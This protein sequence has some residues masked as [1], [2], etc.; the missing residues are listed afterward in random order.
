MS[1]STIKVSYKLSYNYI[2]QVIW[3]KF[4]IHSVVFVAFL[5]N[6]IIKPLLCFMEES[7]IWDFTEA[8]MHVYI[9]KSIGSVLFI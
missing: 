7:K 3:T 5:N 4:I 1:T 6:A 8:F 2:T 9:L